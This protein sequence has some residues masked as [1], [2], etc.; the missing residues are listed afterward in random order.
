MAYNYGF[1]VGYQGVNYP[2][3]YTQYPQYPVQGMQSAPNQQAMTNAV[4]QQGN[5]L[6]GVQNNGIIWVQG[7]AGANAFLVAPNASVML[8]DSDEKVFYIK[9]ADASGMPQPLRIF[10]YT[11]RVGNSVANPITPVSQN[12][13][14]FNPDMYIT[15]EEFEK[16]V[17]EILAIEN[18]KT[19][20][21][22]NKKENEK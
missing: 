7:R 4:P 15:R 14:N 10:D 17:A 18:G 11:E 16:R 1:P 3:Q 13:Q 6:Q 5:Q 21:K 22:E 2:Q 9:S 19:I 20:K 12:N 8:M